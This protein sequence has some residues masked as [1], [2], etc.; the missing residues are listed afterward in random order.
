MGPFRTTWQLR[1]PACDWRGRCG[2][3]E[4]LR[5]LR[6][7]GMLRREAH[8]ST[9]TILELIQIRSADLTC[10]NCQR[11]GLSLEELDDDFDDWDAGRLCE[12]CQQPLAPERLQLFPDARRCATC[13]TDVDTDE[14][15]FCPRCGACLSL[16][17]S[18]GNG[19]ARYQMRCPDCGW[20]GR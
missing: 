20:Q 19:V 2:L 9:D 11:H 16:K 13:S 1:C 5:R 12:I 10:D 15:D 14:P 8:P 6:D 17:T 3:D 4:L 7:L 18:R